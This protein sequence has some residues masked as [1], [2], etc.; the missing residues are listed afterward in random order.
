VANVLSR[1]SIPLMLNYLIE[2]FEQIDISYCYLRVTETEMR[3]ILKST[4]P[5][6]VLEAQHHDRLL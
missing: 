6:R 4:I 5:K 3:V 1:K 2:R